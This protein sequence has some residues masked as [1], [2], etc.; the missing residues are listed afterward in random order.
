[1][2]QSSVCSLLRSQRRRRH[3]L[4]KRPLTFDG[5]LGVISLKVEIFIT[6]ALRISYPTGT[7]FFVTCLG[8]ILSAGG[9]NLHGLSRLFRLSGSP[10][11]QK[12]QNNLSV[13][14]EG[15]GLS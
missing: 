5:L 7:F 13:V 2:K 14:W 10:I 3:V 11:C 6:A 4:P 8:Y 12:F 1:M 15:D 9:L